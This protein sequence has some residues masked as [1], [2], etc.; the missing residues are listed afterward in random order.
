MGALKFVITRAVSCL[1]VGLFFCG[2]VLAATEKFITVADIHFNP[3]ASCEK[4]S[5][6]CATATALRQAPYQVWDAI[7]ARAGYQLAPRYHQETNYFLLKS[8]IAELAR[9]TRQE[10][11]AFILVLGDFLAHG[12]S[13]KYKKYAGDPSTAGYQAFVKKTLQ[14]LTAELKK[15]TSAVAIYPVIGNNDSYTHNYEV[16]PQGAFLQDA[17]T[18]FSLLINDKIAQAEF[19]QQFSNGGYYAIT[20][21]EKNK[22]LIILN[23]VLF[24]TNYHTAA[25]Q[26]AAAAQLTWLAAQLNLAKQQH[27]KVLL[28]FHIPPGVNTFLAIKLPYKIIHY[29]W[30]PVFW[31]AAATELFLETVKPFSTTI[32]G[33]LAAHIHADAFQLIKSADADYIPVLF[34]PSISPIYGN[35]PGYKLFSY[36][37]KTFQLVNVD[38]Y[39][40]PLDSL[41]AAQWKKE[42]NFNTIYQTGCRHC[43]LVN[44]MLRLT[45]DNSL[46]NFYKKYYAVG[47]NAQPITTQNA[48]L[49]YYWCSI[50][51]IDFPTYQRCIKD[52]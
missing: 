48:W 25:M 30:Q 50:Y 26:K 35:N 41:S 36:D 34:T 37:K 5:S 27:Q 49:P 19:R 4:K 29:F 39:Y 52:Y 20:L 1:I 13:Q 38:T 22:R 18:I 10:K 32:I 21:T 23:S 9:I 11:P 2:S 42:Y 24:N 3:F 17:A 16:V 46:V 51:H 12:F 15:I 47:Q 14:F 45:K 8:T 43:L 28:A 33:I 6:P 40:Y 44:G 31:Q 7:L